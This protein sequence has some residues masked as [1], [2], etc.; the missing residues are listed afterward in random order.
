MPELQT[1]RLD[2]PR[3]GVARLTLHRPD[4]LN[5]MTAEM[6]TELTEVAERLRVDDSVRAVVLTGAG[7]GFCAGYDLAAA[8]DFPAADTA[9]LL[10]LQDT[11]WRA[12]HAVYALPKPVVAA[13][14]G[15][16]AGGG[17]SLS[18]AADIRL[19]GAS[20]RFQAVFVRIGLSGGDLGTSWLLPR[21]VGT[22][23]AAELLYT[24]R[25]V[26]AE[27]AVRIG[28][29]NRAVGD[30][31]LA[32][33]AVEL[34]G[35]IAAHAPLAVQLTKRSLRANVDAPALLGALELESR[36]QVAL[37]REPA[38]TEAVSRLRNQKGS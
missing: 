28:L 3:P 8:G 14:H 36:A 33:E 18:L 12:L 4:R 38:T 6:F 25:P 23:L 11:A 32:A 29:A 7:A 35:Q 22:G 19:A 2:E 13:V 26:Y 16:A 1:L 17:F 31:E 21:I 27:E 30:G 9:D 10:A 15:P 5:A 20:A 34:A 37:M 24:G